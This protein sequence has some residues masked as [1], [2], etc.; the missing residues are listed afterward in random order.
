[1]KRNKAV[2]RKKK[3][4]VPKT[5]TKGGSSSLRQSQFSSTP[6]SNVSTTTWP[7]HSPPSSSPSPN[8][9]IVHP[10]K[11]PPSYAEVK[12]PGSQNGRLR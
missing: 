3:V 12:G 7:F 1:M 9:P 2:Q 5:D 4:D 6:A 11:L 10:P 8:M